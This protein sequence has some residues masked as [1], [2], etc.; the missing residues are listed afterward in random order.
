MNK[1]QKIEDTC[2]NADW[3]ILEDFKDWVAQVIVDNKKFYCKVSHKSCRLSNMG[4][5]A[6]KKYN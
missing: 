1:E 2:F 3:L 5:A 4:I 6:L